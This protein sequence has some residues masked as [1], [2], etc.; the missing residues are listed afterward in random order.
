MNKIRLYKSRA[1]GRCPGHQ[2]A[3]FPEGFLAE[4]DMPEITKLPAGVFWGQK[5]F[6]YV[7]GVNDAHVYRE[8]VLMVLDG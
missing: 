3:D 7:G 4:F 6:V 5:F 8:D 1:D 2:V